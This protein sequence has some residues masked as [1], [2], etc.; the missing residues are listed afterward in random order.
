[1]VS[2][3]HQKQNCLFGLKGLLC[4]QIIHIVNDRK[5]VFIKRFVP[6]IANRLWVSGSPRL[7]QSRGVIQIQ[8]LTDESQVDTNDKSYKR[9]IRRLCW[10]NDKV[11]RCSSNFTKKILMET[12]P[13][14]TL[15]SPV[16]RNLFILMHHVTYTH[17]HPFLFLRYSSRTFYWPI[18]KTI[19]NIP[20]ATT[21]RSKGTTTT[22]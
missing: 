7:V 13:R 22:L 16:K 20:L 15:L 17:A 10:A 19:L 3:G 4:R 1:M 21:L 11:G 9:Q 5:A 6:F 8:N 2:V 12:I 14:G 18:K